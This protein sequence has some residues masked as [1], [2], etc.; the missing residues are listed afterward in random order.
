M[1]QAFRDLGYQVDLVTGYAD[2]RKAAIKQVKQN[3]KNGIKYDFMYAEGS[4]MPTI[5][6]EKHHLPTHPFMDWFFFRFCK[7]NNISI[8]LFYRDIHWKF[9][10]YGERLSFLKKKL[11]IISYKYDLFFY[12]KTLCKLYVPSFELLRYLPKYFSRKALELYPG[13]NN[14]SISYDFCSTPLRLFY[15]GGVGVLY[16][17]QELISAVNKFDARNIRLTIC[18]R[19]HEWDEVRHSYPPLTKNINIIH[20]VGDNMEKELQESDIALLYLK[21]TEY[22]SFAM[23]VKLFEYIGFEKPIIANNFSMHGRFV[24][25]NGIGWTIEYS[26]AALIDLLKNLLNHPET[27]R[28]IGDNYTSISSKH[29]WQARAKQVI[30]DLS[31]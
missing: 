18:T 27:I 26:E 16:Q 5:L 31:Q 12:K 29:S 23:P 9:S 21:P 10:F 13:H 1:L 4:T 19:K 2:E 6:T 24:H 17:M 3:I 14:P 15:V 28:K 22:Q 8:G 7:K 30:D 25:D 11:A 20:A